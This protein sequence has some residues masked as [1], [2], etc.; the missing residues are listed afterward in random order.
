MD[1]QDA[2]IS[3]DRQIWRNLLTRLYLKS[4]NCK[5]SLGVWWGNI[6]SGLLYLQCLHLFGFQIS[7]WYPWNLLGL[8]EQ[9]LMP[10]C[11]GSVNMESSLWSLRSHSFPNL[12]HLI[13]TSMPTEWTHQKKRIDLSGLDDLFQTWWPILNCEITVLHLRVFWDN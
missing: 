10:M 9:F 6:I 3:F 1:N 11:K 8:S 13:T 7:V 12:L 4:N 2:L 5:S